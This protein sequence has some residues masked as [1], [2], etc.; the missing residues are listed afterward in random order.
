[1]N[2]NK[3]SIITNNKS[4]KD[5]V[6]IMAL[7]DNTRNGM[8]TKPT[9]IYH[10][11]EMSLKIN[12]EYCSKNILFLADNVENALFLESNGCKVFK[13]FDDI[14]TFIKIDKKHKLKFW[15]V[16]W[17]LK[18]FKEVL[19][20]DW[21]TICLKW[22][23]NDFWNW[24]RYLNTPK[25]IKIPDYWATVN[26]GV[27][28]VNKYWIND[29]EK[30]VNVDVSEPNDE[31]IWK[32]ILPKDITNRVEYWWGDRIVNI[33]DHKKDMHYITKNTYFVHIR[34][35]SLTNHIRDY[36]QKIINE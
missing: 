29:M 9:K 10:E 11:I 1:M 30:N 3:N 27:Y 23:D 15:M 13:I 35:L 34:D 14:P 33:W 21:D 5:P 19:W 16:L 24:S 28:F 8:T 4:K 6:I 17:A 22:P 2:N 7:Y 31:L 26:C 32:S 36:Y 18:K 20:L 25:F 12:K